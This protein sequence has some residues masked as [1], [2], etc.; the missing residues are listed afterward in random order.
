MRRLLDREAGEEAELNDA[1]LLG[2]ERRE[3]VKR[4]IDREH[5]GGAGVIP[6]VELLG[7][8][9]RGRHRPIADGSPLIAG[10]HALDSTVCPERGKRQPWPPP[11]D[12]LVLVLPWNGAVHDPETGLYWVRPGRPVRHLLQRTRD[13]RTVMLPD[14]FVALFEDEFRMDREPD[15]PADVYVLRARGDELALYRFQR[16]GRCGS[17]HFVGLGASRFVATFC[18]Y[19]AV[20]FELP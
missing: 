18:S 3:A 1:L 8:E 2:V 15:D 6:R 4:V 9:P 17:S 7:V 13:L 16:P 11:P 10:S 12:I 20:V 5:V 19:Q 14:G